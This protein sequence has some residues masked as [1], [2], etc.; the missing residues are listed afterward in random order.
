MRWPLHM[1]KVTS[2]K[3]CATN[4]TSINCPRTWEHNSKK[5][6]RLQSLRKPTTYSSSTL[7]KPQ[8]P[9]SRPTPQWGLRLLWPRIRLTLATSLIC[10]PRPTFLAE[11]R[12]LTGP[13]PL[14]WSTP[15][16]TSTI[17]SALPKLGTKHGNGEMA[18]EMSKEHPNSSR[19]YPWSSLCNIT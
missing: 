15:L 12:N 2:M 19:I 11:S 6:D 4:L 9:P 3:S 13:P 17:S 14:Q 7:K 16:P 18:A 5:M 10:Y 8:R 1:A